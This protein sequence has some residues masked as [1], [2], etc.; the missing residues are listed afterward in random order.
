MLA[1]RKL[2]LR[3]SSP[4]QRRS[5]RS[6]F[7]FCSL[8]AVLTA[9][10]CASA[11]EVRQAREPLRLSLVQSN[12]TTLSMDALLGKPTLLFFFTTYDSASQLAFI[13]LSSLVQRHSEEIHVLGIAVQ[14]EAAELLPMYA[15]ALSLPVRLAYEPA[16][17]VLAGKSA[18][19]ELGGIPQYV[20]LSPQGEVLKR[21]EGVMDYEALSEFVEMDD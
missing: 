17:T 14:P 12:L 2:N 3:R 19:G 6:H 21:R 10:A 1:R 4:G 13:A 15:E 9:T 7:L 11:P 5:L 8:F 18:L 20:L 16:G